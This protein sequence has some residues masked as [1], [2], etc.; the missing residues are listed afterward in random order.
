MATDVTK[1]AVYLTWLNLAAVA[2]EKLDGRR[3]RLIVGIRYA[4]HGF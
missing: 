4:S 2:I 1:L 3:R